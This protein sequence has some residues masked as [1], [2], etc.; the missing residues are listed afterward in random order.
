LR[1]WLLVL[2]VASTSFEPRDPEVL[3]GAALLQESKLDEAREA[4]ESSLRRLEAGPR[5]SHELALALFYRGALSA[6]EGEEG[7]AREYMVR[8]L[9]ADPDLGPPGS[10]F[11]PE[12]RSAFEWARKGKPSARAKAGLL[13]AV[14]AGGVLTTAAL[15]FA[16]AGS[17]ESSS[18]L[19]RTS[20]TFNGDLLSG[21]APRE[22]P[23]VVAATGI[24]DAR[25]DWI[26]PGVL[27]TLELD[28]SSHQ[29]RAFSNPTTSVEALL[30][31]V[32]EPGTYTLLLSRRDALGGPGTFTLVVTHP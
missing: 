19:G 4:L 10:A 13:G 2:L 12:A 31:V 26:E 22:F 29:A 28:D 23:L 27:L 17:M 32:V 14:V 7:K 1:A 25:V 20:E 16:G 3:K 18:S 8:A 21:S 11:P 30:S 6:R 24:V 9:T 5:K 15:V